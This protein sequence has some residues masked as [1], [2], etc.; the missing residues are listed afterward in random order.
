MNKRL[1]LR[2][3]RRWHKDEIAVLTIYSPLLLFLVSC[4]PTPPAPM[5]YVEQVQ[6]LTV[7]SCGYRP[8]AKTIEGIQAK[9]NEALNEPQTMAR[10]LSGSQRK[11]PVTG[12]T[13]AR[14]LSQKAMPPCSDPS[15]RLHLAESDTQLASAVFRY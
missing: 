3:W 2:R 9:G 14:R 6:E 13:S 12:T 4:S 7:K 11:D 10:H 5:S 1:T 15:F 8:S